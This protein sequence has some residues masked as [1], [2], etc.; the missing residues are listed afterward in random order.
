[1]RVVKEIINANCRI[2]IFNWNNKY[3]I[4]LETPMM[5]QTYKIDQYDVA[6][7]AE[8]IQMLDEQFIDKAMKIKIFDIA[9]GQTTEQAHLGSFLAW[10]LVPFPHVGI[11]E[12]EPICGQSRTNP[13][14]SCPPD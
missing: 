5:E 10:L 7:E 3:L 4:K 1:M 13:T 8:V 14:T 11:L 2:T 9:S 6:S 12:L